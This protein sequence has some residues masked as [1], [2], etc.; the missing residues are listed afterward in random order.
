[1]TRRQ[2]VATAAGIAATAG[3]ADLFAV[4][5]NRLIVT[6]HVAPAGVPR[7]ARVVQL[8][9]LHLRRVSRHERQV[10][11]AAA[12]L[13]PDL[14]VFTG[15]SI[16]RR[17]DLEL[18]ADFLALLPPGVAQL[19]ILG[20]WEYWAGLDRPA[21]ET[22][23]G[24]HGCRLLVDESVLLSVRGAALRVTGF[25][26]LIGGR[27]NIDHALGG[28]TAGEAHLILAHCPA[29]R[30]VV[31]QVAAQSLVRGEFDPGLLRAPVML[32]GHTHGGQVNLW[33][34]APFV[35]VGSG[36]YLRGWYRDGSISLYVSRGIG[37]SVLPVRFNAPPEVA[38]FELPL[39]R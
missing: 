7:V 30:D 20:N 36:R 39:V 23:Y 8:S 1:M 14:I 28:A 24:R 25:D 22:V 4:E 13:S 15:D 34:W 5:P 32:S 35:P 18:L 16:D 27:P 11:E 9:D 38:Y 17:D 21:L 26:S 2:W 31:A 6:R 19:A 33:G 29:H 37:M 3:A 10:A 12:A